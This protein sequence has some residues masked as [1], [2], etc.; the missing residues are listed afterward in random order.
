MPDMSVMPAVRQ[1]NFTD[2]LCTADWLVGFKVLKT[3]GLGRQAGGKK[4]LRPHLRVLETRLGR[5]Y[6]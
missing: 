6:S 2:Q 1:S 4:K 3:S 5:V